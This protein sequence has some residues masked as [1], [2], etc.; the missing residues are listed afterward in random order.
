MIEYKTRC[1]FCGKE[2]AILLPEADYADWT[3]GK[4]AQDAFPYLS[5]ETRE[6]L[7]SGICPSCWD[8]MF[9]SES[10]EEDD[11]F[12]DDV[13]ECGYNP[14]TGAYDFDC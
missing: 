13:D 10:E 9:P 8:S 3:N 1:P 14:Y 11:Y 4:N 2:T 5:A 7:I 6:S 12:D